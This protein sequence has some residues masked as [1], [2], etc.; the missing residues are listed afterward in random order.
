MFNSNDDDMFTREKVFFYYYY[1]TL[2]F[3]F[4]LLPR[5]LMKGIFFN[6]YFLFYVEKKTTN[7]YTMIKNSKSKNLLKL[8]DRS[9]IKVFENFDRTNPK[10]N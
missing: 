9:K 5:G 1:F 6:P 8:E 4:L 2:S 10:T 7:L 3:F